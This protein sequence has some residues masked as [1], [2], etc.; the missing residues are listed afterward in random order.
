MEDV[1]IALK[2]LLRVKISAY[3]A[4]CT[5]IYSQMK[6]CLCITKPFK[7]GSVHLNH[8]AKIGTSGSARMTIFK[9]NNL[10]LNSILLF[11]GLDLFFLKLKLLF[12]SFFDHSSGH[13]A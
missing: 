7:D 13:R 8:F 9:T 3:N 6:I 4:T 5:I 10:F 11:L 2:S 1:V 12:K